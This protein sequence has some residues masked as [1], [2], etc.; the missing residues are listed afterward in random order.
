MLVGFQA[1]HSLPD[2]SQNLSHSASNFSLLGIQNK[3][4]CACSFAKAAS[5]GSM[6]VV[7]IECEADGIVDRYDLTLVE[8]SPILHQCD[9]GG[10]LESHAYLLPLHALSF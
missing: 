4:I 1:S 3:A 5:G 8:F 2:P 7:G 6:E 10:R 9:V